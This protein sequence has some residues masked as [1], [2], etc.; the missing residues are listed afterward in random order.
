MTKPLSKNEMKVLLLAVSDEMTNREIA[1]AMNV[2]PNYVGRCLDSIYLKIGVKGR[3]GAVKWA[4]RN[5]V[6]AA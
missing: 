3:V 1:H 6:V 5:G 4:I 2:S